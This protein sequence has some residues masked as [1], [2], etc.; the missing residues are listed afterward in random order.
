MDRILEPGQ[1][2]ALA[3]RSIPRVI[4]PPR[5]VFARR[6]RRLAA[7]A[8][9]HSLAGYLDLV[10]AIARWQDAALAGPMPTGPTPEGIGIAREHAMPPLPALGMARD[11]RWIEGLRDLCR[12][13]AAEA[14]F[15]PSV[16][17]TCDRLHAA[18]DA[19]LEAVADRV[20]GASGRDADPAAALFVSAALS[21]PF[22]ALALAL[23][24][25]VIA[26]Q[27]PTHCPVCGS[28]PV[29][30]LVRSSAPY[31]GYRYLQCGLCQAQW[32]RV[33]VECTSCGGSRDVAYHSIE[34][35]L[36]AI[37]AETCDDCHGY[38]KI[39]YQEHDPEVEPL[40]D[41]L[42]SVALDLMLCEAGFHRAAANPL[43]WQPAD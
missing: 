43:Y 18:S 4:L 23:D 16:A 11:R 14:G 29:A 8:P 36:P 31:G 10:A 26:H 19:A 39:F 1:I 15:P 6:A 38:L 20:L 28:A 3:S 13:I 17:A 7:L 35:G 9:G 34:G 22:T 32:H 41:D 37:R 5:E 30:S 27:P 24:P 25:A 2:E 12:S 40:A 42:A 21:V 33:R